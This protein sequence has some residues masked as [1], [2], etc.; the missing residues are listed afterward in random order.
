MAIP[1]KF[2]TFCYYPSLSSGASKAWLQKNVELSPGV[3][4]RF[5]SDD[6]PEKFRHKYF[7]IT[8]GHHY[9]K[10][11]M[12]QRLGLDDS[13][14]VIGDSGGFQLATGA[15]DWDP[16]FKETIFTWLENNSDI[17]LNLDLPPRVKLTGKFDYCL[18]TSVDNFYSNQTHVK[19]VDNLRRSTG[20]NK[21]Q[22]TRMFNQ[23]KAY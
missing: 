4:S 11:D 10:E 14:Q 22:L 7:L 12:R 17:A 1:T 18:E 19:A 16:S 21:S 5:Y 3:T 13:V 6:Y 8:A 2:D 15:I 9:K 23:L 20:A